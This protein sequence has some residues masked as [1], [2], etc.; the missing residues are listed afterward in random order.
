VVVSV[1]PQDGFLH[2]VSEL[3]ALGVD[4]PDTKCKLN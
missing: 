2:E 4:R 1:S 3:D